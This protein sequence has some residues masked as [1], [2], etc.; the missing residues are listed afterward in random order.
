[1]DISYTKVELEEWNE[2]QARGSENAS[3]PDLH[4]TS[5]DSTLPMVVILREYYLARFRFNKKYFR[6]FKSNVFG[7]VQL[8]EDNPDR[9]IKNE[10][11][12][13]IEDDGAEV[14]GGAESE[15]Q[16]PGAQSANSTQNSTGHDNTNVVNGLK[17]R[18]NIELVVQLERCDDEVANGKPQ[19][20]S[21]AKKSKRT[22]QNKLKN[23]RI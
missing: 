13:E 1:M 12:I 10:I 11:P 7:I 14:V 22:T 20:K 16:L 9:R 15:N 21:G 3:L 4:S 5:M 18:S 6:G 19:A 2:I 23:L 17:R 8:A